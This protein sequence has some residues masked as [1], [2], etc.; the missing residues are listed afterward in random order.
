MDTGCFSTETERR[1]ERLN[2]RG[3][4][5]GTERTRAILDELGSPDEKLKIIHVAGTNGKGSVT[6][7]IGSIICSSGDKVG[8]FTSPAVYGVKEQYRINGKEVDSW[9]S[10]YCFNA[11]FATQ[12]GKNATRFEVETAAAL[13]MFARENCKYAVIEC[14]MGG[15]YDATNAVNK[16]EIAVITSVSLE[17]TKYLGDTLEKIC[18]QKAGIIK[19][20]PAV[21][22]SFQPPEV[23]ESFKGRG[24]IFADEPEILNK[25]G[26]SFL[27]GGE[28]YTLEM[29]GAA[30]PYNAALAFKVA[31]LL[32]IDKRFYGAVG[33]V[34]LPG[35]NE[36][37]KAG[38]KTYRLDGAH[39]P[40][41]IA[42]LC[43]SLRGAYP[44]IIYGCLSD[45]D[46][47]GCVKQLAEVAGSLTAVQSDSPRAMDIES[48][49]AACKKYFNRAVC[50]DGIAEALEKADGNF[51]VVC[52]SFTLLKE[53]KQWIEKRL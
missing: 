13:Y 12:A 43:K 6:A 45:K 20:C 48:I 18:V 30:Q 25:D 9:V 29:C 21:V 37:I 42:V 14:G 7:Y 35:R 16:K 2:K 19:D 27:Y 51:I 23:A 44:E 46:V 32:K 49:Y 50:A 4:D 28:R 24:A 34:S 11:V 8:T 10:E 3:M 47:G 5:F 41:G 15:L 33:G 53:A 39:N 36:I 38:G 40:A 52:G 26:T 22:S 31:E 17:H 1:L